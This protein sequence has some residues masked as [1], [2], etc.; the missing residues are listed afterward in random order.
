MNDV[1]ERSHDLVPTLG[2]STYIKPSE[3]EWRP[4]RFEKVSIKVLYE[5]AER[6][7][8]TCLL[9]LEPGA[10]IPFHKHPEI[11][12]SLVLEGSVEDHDGVATA[13]DYVWRKPG[14]LHDNRSPGGAVLFAV[15]RKPNIYYNAA[16]ESAGF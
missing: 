11:E 9:K 3:M 15:Y 12:Q 13:G 7:E 10:Y 6:G 8:M 5:D 16:K 14:S 1:P 2:G 4:T